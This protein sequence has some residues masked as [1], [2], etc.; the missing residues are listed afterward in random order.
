M[1]QCITKLESPSLI[2]EDIMK[3]MIFILS[4]IVAANAQ[5]ARNLV[6]EEKAKKA[7]L[8]I[9]TTDWSED[10]AKVLE[11]DALPV[12][13]RG[14]L[15]RYDVVVELEG[16]KFPASYKVTVEASG[17]TACYIVSVSVPRK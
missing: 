9:M 3:S 15:Y 2:E 14:D 17:P 6:C 11:M 7:T 1:M 16:A 10:Q 8:A 4:L 5:A 13:Q 12:A